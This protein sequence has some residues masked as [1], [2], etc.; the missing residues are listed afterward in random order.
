M[1]RWESTI[2]R[3]GILYD[4][5]PYVYKIACRGEKTKAVRFL[6]M[7]SPAL[8]KQKEGVL[9]LKRNSRN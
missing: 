8:L 1:I 7:E 5:I 6:V 9:K 2:L 4:V 3:D